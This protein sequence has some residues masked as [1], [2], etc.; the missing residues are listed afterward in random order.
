MNNERIIE[1]DFLQIIRSV[2]LKWKLLLVAASIG[3]LVAEVAT[4]FLADQEDLYQATS[5]V[6]CAPDEYYSLSAESVQLM[7]TFVDIVQ[8]SSVIE[9]ANGIMGNVYPDEETIYEMISVIYDNSGT[10]NNSVILKIQAESPNAQEAMD[11]ANAMAEAFSL[12]MSS[13]MNRG[14]VHVLDSAKTAIVSYEAEEYN[15][16]YIAIGAVGGMLLLA[17][18]IVLK[19][20]FVVNLHSVNDATLFGK[21]EVV[22]VIPDFN[23]C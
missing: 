18:W 6:Y 14:E 11:V 4:Y 13:I 7:R 9:R 8:S 23:Q 17:V 1:I 5:S 16:L 15:I 22:G 20:I 10:Y 19:E 21:L 12:E 3:I 2:V